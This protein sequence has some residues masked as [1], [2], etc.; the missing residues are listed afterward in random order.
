MTETYALTKKDSD[1]PI[2]IGTLDHICSLWGELKYRNAPDEEFSVKRV[3][4]TTVKEFTEKEIGILLE[5][6]YIPRG[7]E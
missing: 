6:S 1:L 7:V 5:R 3:Q 2:D 4:I